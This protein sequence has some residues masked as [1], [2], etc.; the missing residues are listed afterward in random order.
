MAMHYICI[1]KGYI[2]YVRGGEKEKGGRENIG[3]GGIQH[4]RSRR[5]G[6]PAEVTYSLGDLS[7][8]QK[9]LRLTR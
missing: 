7:N 9:Q 2:N 8:G 6:L 3:G 5:Q 1:L 4:R